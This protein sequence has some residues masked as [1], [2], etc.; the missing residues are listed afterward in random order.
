MNGRKILQ[1][2]LA[3]F[4]YV[5][6][7]SG[8]RLRNQLRAGVLLKIAK[9]RP[10]ADIRAER[11]VVNPVDA[12]LT[13][14]FKNAS[15]AAV[16]RNL[17]CGSAYPDNLHALFEVLP[18]TLRII[19]ICTRLVAANLY[20]RSAV[21]ALIGINVK[22]SLSVFIVFD[23]IRL[24]GRTNSNAVVAR[25]TFCWVKYNHSDFSF[26]PEN[27]S[28]AAGKNTARKSFFSF[29]P[30][31]LTKQHNLRRFNYLA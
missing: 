14:I 9:M 4:L 6:D 8:T 30:L 13:Y 20:A 15:P 12:L 29:S 23:N 3:V 21:Y 27:L 16:E 10:C 7:N 18:E 11:N 5:I 31:R 19:D 1:R 17:D 24:N 25:N 2:L 26:F 22:N 28:R